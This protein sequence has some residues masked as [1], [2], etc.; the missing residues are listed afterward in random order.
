MIRKH[1][2]YPDILQ[3][4]YNGI[5]NQ[6]LDYPYCSQQYSLQPADKRISQT[7]SRYFLYGEIARLFAASFRFVKTTWHN[8]RLQKLFCG[9]TLM[10]FVDAFYIF[11]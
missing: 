5:N 4:K 6:N 9:I 1:T 2:E 3:T 10:Q 7:G 8:E 11:M